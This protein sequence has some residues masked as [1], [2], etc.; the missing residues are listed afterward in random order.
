MSF[1]PEYLV[2]HL[3]SIVFGLAM[4]VTTWKRPNLGRVL[5]VVLFGWAAAT[6]AY[7]GLTTPWVYLDYASLTESPVYK[8]I[9]LGPFARHVT[10]YVL[11]VAIAQAMIAIGLAMRGKLARVAAIGAIVFLIAVAPLGI[12]SAFPTTLLLAGALAILLRRGFEES[13][14]TITRRPFSGRRL[15]H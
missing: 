1:R 4:L 6:N 7:T 11:M 15:A 14:F 12:G 8:A 5:F 10:A 2:P 13:L 3:V 9:I